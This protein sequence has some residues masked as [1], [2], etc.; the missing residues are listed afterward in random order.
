MV[1]EGKGP[2][3]MVEN[4]VLNRVSGGTRGK[5]E[6][7]SHQPQL[8]CPLLESF[9]VDNEKAYGEQSFSNCTG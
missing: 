8:F 5:I 2:K 6:L 3:I 7:C 1:N 4:S 9:S